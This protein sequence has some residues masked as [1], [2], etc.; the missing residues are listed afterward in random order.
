MKDPQDTQKEKKLLSKKD[1]TLLLVAGIAL[2]IALCCQGWFYWPWFGG[3][4]IRF[5]TKLDAVLRFDATTTDIPREELFIENNTEL[6]RH[7]ICRY[8]R[9]IAL[10]TE[11]GESSHA[12][13][14]WESPLLLY[15]GGTPGNEELATLQEICDELNKIPGF[16]GVTRVDDEASAN[17]IYTFM[18]ADQYD[19][20]ER[21]HGILGSLGLT[22]VTF[23]EP[24]TRIL[25][26]DIGI[27]NTDDRYS[28][29]VFSKTTTIWEEFIQGTGLLNDTLLYSETLFYN[30]AYDVPKATAFDW[31]VFRILYLPQIQNGMTYLNCLPYIYEYLR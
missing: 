12:I 3:N 6:S 11:F 2:A 1:K 5:N 16:P 30:G 7:D 27:K 22:C 23:D 18:D 15:I 13:S 26:V 24:G 21:S 10:N 14:K 31:I 8:F 17:F 28:E 29:G 9:D 19:K 25:H 20:W 4:V